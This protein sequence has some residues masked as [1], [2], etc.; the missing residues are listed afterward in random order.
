RY[1]TSRFR[2]LRPWRKLPNKHQSRHLLK[3]YFLASNSAIEIRVPPVHWRNRLA[4]PKQIES[5]GFQA[6]IRLTASFPNTF[7]LVESRRNPCWAVL[8]KN[9]VSSD[10]SPVNHALA[11]ACLRWL[12]NVSA[13]QRLMI[14][15]QR[16]LRHRR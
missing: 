7:A 15:K 13:I 10:D 4:N 11:G 8:Q 12:R 6:S 2:S 9:R 1:R 14:G 5:Y 16:L 3:T